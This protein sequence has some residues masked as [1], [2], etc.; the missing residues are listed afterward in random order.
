MVV[1]NTQHETA[2]AIRRDGQ[3]AVFIRLKSGKLVCERLT[4]MQFRQQWQES[5]YP[6]QET[7]IRFLAHADAHGA[8]QEARKGLQKLQDRDRRMVANLF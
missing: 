8:T 6:L 4:E 3:T 5:S 7:L 2:I 1:I